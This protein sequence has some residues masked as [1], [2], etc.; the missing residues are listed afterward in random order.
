V[1]KRDLTIKVMVLGVKVLDAS[2]MVLQLGP[3]LD[4]PGNSFYMTVPIDQADFY[5]VGKTVLTSVVK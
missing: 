4:D 2:S 3:S 1:A 5:A